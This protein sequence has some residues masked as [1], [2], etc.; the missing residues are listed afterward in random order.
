MT[1]PDPPQM[2]IDAVKRSPFRN[3]SAVWLVP[4]LAVI[5]SIGVAWKSYSDRGTLVSITFSVAAGV[6]PGETTVKFR[7][8]VIGSVE[9]VHFGP[10]LQTVIVDAR[11]DKEVAKTLPADSQFWI[12][13]PEVSTRG[14]SGLS[15]VLSGVYIEGAWEPVTGSK[16]RAF[17]GLDATPVVRPG[18]E[19][20]R[21]TLRSTDAS[22]LPEGAPVFFRGVEVGRLDVA[23]VSPGGDSAIVEAFIN[24]PYDQYITTATR[25]WDT[26]GFTVKLGPSGL[27]LNVASL[28]SLLSGG[29]AFDN[30]FT[31]GQPLTDATVFNLFVDEASARQSI[32]TQIGENAV[33]VVINF[34]GSVNGLNAGAP[35]DYRGLRVGQVTGINAYIETSPLGARIVRLRTAIEIDP[36]A[37]GLDGDTGG[38]EVMAFLRDAVANGLRARLTTTS[39]F[40]AALKIELVELPDEA[41]EQIVMGPDDLPILPNVASDLPNFTATAEGVLER[42]NA[43]PIEEVMQQAISLMAS[44]EA[45]AASEG[46]RAAPD[47]LVALLED[48]RALLNKEDTQALPTELRLAV[49]DLRKVVADLQ[50]RGA[51]DNLASV[52]ESADKIAADL[53]TAAQDFPQLVADL[54][55]LAAKAKALKAEELIDQTTKLLASADAV[56][57]T[58]AARALPQDLSAALAE[59]QGALKDL[60][61]GGAVQNANAALA[62]AKDAAESVASAADDLPKLTAELDGLVQKASGLIATYSTKSA[63]NGE[64]LDLLRDLQTATKAVTQLART[65]ERNPNSLLI[66]R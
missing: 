59:I 40:S 31:G 44:I 46:T 41:P 2:Q 25:F 17:Q 30:A 39:I 58:D 4:L 51:V 55:D 27:D 35:V 49:A 9:N 45:V 20:R 53:A 26:S 38:G 6:V 43:L 36:Q 32:F 65:I 64:V 52:L 5:V 47:A 15:T 42:I 34:S 22:L 61:E 57:G 28:G 56:L 33:K 11:I 50:E 29:V 18:H 13:R 66:G 21:I 16:V 60:R 62:S 10:G 7:D 3:L 48:T 1:L 14:I 54:R 8:V 24:A 19:G 12:V 37:L 23:R 63:F